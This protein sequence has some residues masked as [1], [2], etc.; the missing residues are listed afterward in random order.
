MWSL[1]RVLPAA[2][3]F[4]S[5]LLQSMS[6]EDTR[7]LLRKN[8]EKVRELD[9]KHDESPIDTTVDFFGDGVRGSNESE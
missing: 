4:V 2:F 1:I 8:A 5:G 3:K 6:V 7:D 9:E